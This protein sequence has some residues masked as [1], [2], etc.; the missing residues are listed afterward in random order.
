MTIPMGEMVSYGAL[1]ERIGR[2][3]AQRAVAQ[4]LKRNP[5]IWRVPCHRVVRSNGALGGFAFGIACK[6]QL[7]EWEKIR[8]K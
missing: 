2:P 4:A 1:A 3:G 7:L 6:A 8:I 5:V